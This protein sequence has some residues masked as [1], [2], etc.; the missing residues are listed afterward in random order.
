MCFLPPYQSVWGYIWWDNLYPI[1]H[2]TIH[3]FSS[4]PTYG[5]DPKV[6]IKKKYDAQEEVYT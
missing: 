1:D 4:I 3:K 2:D 5:E 6:T